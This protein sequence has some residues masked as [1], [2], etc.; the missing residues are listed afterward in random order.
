MA[1]RYLTKSVALAALAVWAAPVLAGSPVE[2]GA[3]HA[4]LLMLDQPARQVIIGDPTVA[5]ISVESPTRVVVFG[6]RVGS[7]SLMV[8]D[9]GHRPVLDAPV[10]VQPGGSGNVTITYGTGKDV[11]TGGSNAV[12]ACATTCVRAADKPSGAAPAAPAPA[13]AAPQ[14]APAK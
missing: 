8:L 9:G 6:K 1:G 2:V 14:A 13:P 7:T 12:F 5:D 11:K 3:G 10:V 4:V